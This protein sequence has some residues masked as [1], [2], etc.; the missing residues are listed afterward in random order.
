MLLHVLRA[1]EASR[2]ATAKLYS[3]CS[4]SMCSAKELA[5]VTKADEGELLEAVAGIER[6]VFQQCPDIVSCAMSYRT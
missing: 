1:R 3:F 5:Q 2:K 6:E 4:I